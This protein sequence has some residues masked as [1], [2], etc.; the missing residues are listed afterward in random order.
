M[1]VVVLLLIF[2]RRRRRRRRSRRRRRRCRRSSI[3]GIRIRTHSIGMRCI[4][5]VRISRCG[6]I[7]R[8]ITNL[9]SSMC[10]RIRVDRGMCI[11]MIIIR[12]MCSG[13]Q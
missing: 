12:I 4:I 8:D 9:M 5:R 13:I 6:R 10:S 7:I 2:I 3:N 11:N 1:I